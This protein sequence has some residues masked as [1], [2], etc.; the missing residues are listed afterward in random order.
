MN[1]QFH[2]ANCLSTTLLKAYQL[3]CVVTI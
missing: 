3:H 1:N 2:R